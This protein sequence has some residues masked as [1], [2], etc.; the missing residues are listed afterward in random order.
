M[1]SNTSADQERDKRYEWKEQG[2]VEVHEEGKGAPLDLTKLRQ[3]PAVEKK[4][5]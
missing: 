3:P 4:N 1:S 2:D 5:L